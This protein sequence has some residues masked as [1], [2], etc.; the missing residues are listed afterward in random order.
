MNQVTILFFAT[1]RDLTHETRIIRTIPDDMVIGG[2]K[3]LLVLEYPGLV[4]IIN[5]VIVSMNH[6]FSFNDATITANAEIALFPPV[7]GG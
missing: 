6:E 3:D 2:L 7:S 1:L 5:S 4:E